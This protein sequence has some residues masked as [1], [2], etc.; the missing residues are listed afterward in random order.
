MHHE[1]PNVTAD[2]LRHRQHNTELEGSAIRTWR[3]WHTSSRF[4]LILLLM[5]LND[6]KKS[7]FIR[8]HFH[9]RSSTAARAKVC[10]N[11]L[12]QTFPTSRER[13]REREAGQK[14]SAIHRRTHSHI[15]AHAYTLSLS[16]KFFCF[17]PF[18]YFTYV[19]SLSPSLLW[20]MQDCRLV[21][22]F[23]THRNVW[24]ASRG[25]LL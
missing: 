16:L 10:H 6:I 8:T 4:S 13:E 24:R 9:S 15:H 17:C 25:S 23:S 19:V 1:K 21:F 2:S 7:S 18:C 5:P 12:T 3:A 22:H 11:P 20:I 14:S